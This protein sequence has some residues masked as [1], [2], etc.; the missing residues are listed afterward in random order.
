M[1]RK[2]SGSLWNIK[3]IAYDGQRGRTGRIRESSS[4]PVVAESDEYIKKE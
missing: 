1:I 2:P 3:E 4:S